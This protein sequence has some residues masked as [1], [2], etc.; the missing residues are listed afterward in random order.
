MKLDITWFDAG[1]VPYFVYN[2]KAE[3]S[4]IK[5]CTPKDSRYRKQR[6]D[7]LHNLAGL[8]QDR[9][10]LHEQYSISY[11]CRYDEEADEVELEDGPMHSN[12]I[13]THGSKHTVSE[14][15]G[16]VPQAGA[17]PIQSSYAAAVVSGSAKRDER[18][19]QWYSPSVN[20]IADYANLDSSRHHSYG[21][22]LQE[23]GYLSKPPQP[24]VS[25][26]RRPAPL[27]RPTAMR[28]EGILH[29]SPYSRDD[30]SMD[31]KEQHQHGHQHSHSAPNTPSQRSVR[32]DSDRLLL[33]MPLTLPL[34]DDYVGNTRN[35]EQWPRASSS[36]ARPSP[37]PVSN[38]R[39]A[40]GQGQSHANANGHARGSGSG[41]NSYALVVAN[42]LSATTN[43]SQN[44]SPKMP[45]HSQS[46]ASH[47]K[48]EH[49]R[50]K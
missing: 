40:N 24:A 33:P 9:L 7:T 50:R 46:N 39:V 41:G 18:P 28:I 36:S 30:A 6:S 38:A 23:N 15:A 45:Q 1:H 17:R 27:P 31:P 35:E 32:S 8:A 25:H 3:P 21:S 34:V 44:P 5:S 47:S 49:L 37:V 14:G 42:S 10:S 19:Q 11:E 29:N 43:S 22:I 12:N 20:D 4:N 13:P 2:T 26:H 48:R 16:V